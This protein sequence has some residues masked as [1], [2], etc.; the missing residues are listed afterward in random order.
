MDLFLFHTY[1][2]RDEGDLKNADNGKEKIQKVMTENISERG[3]NATI[4]M[5]RI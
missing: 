4:I 3:S 1:F 2:L 5:F